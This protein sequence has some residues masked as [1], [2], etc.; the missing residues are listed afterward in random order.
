MIADLLGREDGRSVPV[1]LRGSFVKPPNVE[2]KRAK[3]L[4]YIEVGLKTLSSLGLM[5]IINF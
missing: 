5:W 3:E 4:W 2:D 1:E